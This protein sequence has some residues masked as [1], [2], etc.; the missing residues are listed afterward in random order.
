MCMSCE[1]HRFPHQ[2]ATW[3]TQVVHDD[4]LCVSLHL[5]FVL[6]CCLHCGAGQKPSTARHDTVSL[7]SASKG[8]LCKFLNL[9]IIMMGKCCGVQGLKLQHC[10]S[11]W[12][13]LKYRHAGGCKVLKAACMSSDQTWIEVILSRNQITDLSLPSKFLMLM[14]TGHLARR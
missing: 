4:C 5:M 9:H 13:W 1:A 8:G 10:R 14:L 7:V 6:P 12:A 2:G 3:S 11:H